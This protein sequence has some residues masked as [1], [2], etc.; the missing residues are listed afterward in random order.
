MKTLLAVGALGLALML[1]TSTAHAQTPAPKVGWIDLQRTLMETRVGKQ[2][3]DRLEN[4][5]N[6][7]Q[8]KVNDLKEKLMAPPRS[9]RSSAWS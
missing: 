8:A 7:K 6:D 1:T 9:S 4:E 5:K 3:K 2:A